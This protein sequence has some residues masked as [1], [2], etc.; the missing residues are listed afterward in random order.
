MKDDAVIIEGTILVATEDQLTSCG[1]LYLKKGSIVKVARYVKD[2]H[3]DI[4]VFRNHEAE[5]DDNTHWLAKE[6]ARLAT[7][8]EIIMWENDCYFI[9]VIN[10]I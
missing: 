4:K 1:I 10:T 8:D 3:D 5:D 2:W 7:N 6:K 9:N